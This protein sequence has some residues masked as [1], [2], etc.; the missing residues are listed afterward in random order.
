[1]DELTTP[2]PDD[3]ATTLE[4]PLAF[5]EPEV[6]DAEVPTLIPDDSL[7]LDEEH[8]VSTPL[9]TELPDSPAP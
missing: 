1:V 3:S 7:D 9:A 5:A 6:G 2:I 4:D 8:A